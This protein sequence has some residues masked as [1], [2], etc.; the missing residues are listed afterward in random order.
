[1]FLLLVVSRIAHSQDCGSGKLRQARTASL[2][3]SG[4]A[5]LSTITQKNTE[6][7]LGYVGRYGIGFGPDKP[8]LSLENL[9]NQFTHEKGAYCLFFLT[10]CIPDMG[11]F[12]GLEP[13]PMLSRWKISYFEWLGLNKTYTV[14]ASVLDDIEGINGCAGEFHAQARRAMKT[15]PDNIELD[16]SFEMGKWWLVD[17]VDSVP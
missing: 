3:Q 12:K 6:G 15:A 14:R 7:L 9:R 2:R 13:D 8:R 5:V 16:F 11:R 1:M 17:T 4:I 10:A